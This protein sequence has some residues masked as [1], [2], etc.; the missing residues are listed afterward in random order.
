LKICI[1]TRDTI[2]L[3]RVTHSHSTVSYV[4]TTQYSIRHTIIRTPIIHTY[5]H[6]HTQNLQCK[7]NR[8]SSSQ[9]VSCFFPCFF[10]ASR[11][12][13]ISVSSSSYSIIILYV[14][15]W[16]I[17]INT[18]YTCIDTVLSYCSTVLLGKFIEIDCLFPISTKSPK[19]TGLR[20]LG[21]T[22]PDPPTS[23]L[24]NHFS[25]LG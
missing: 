6:T 16:L 11:V 1:F 24:A 12:S 4:H 5:T 21:G 22:P 10:S 9:I 20:R 14:Q 25:M 7:T 13:V 17:L 15:Y 3:Y 23:L 8:K 18:C 2:I 19:K